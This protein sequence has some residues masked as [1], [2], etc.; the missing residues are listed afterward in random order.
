MGARESD[1]GGG[2]GGGVVIVSHLL[3][4]PALSVLSVLSHSHTLARDP[5]HAICCTVRALGCEVPLLSKHPLVYRHSSA[6]SPTSACESPTHHHFFPYT[7]NTILAH[8]ANCAATL[9]T[10]IPP[11]TVHTTRHSN[12]PQSNRQTYIHHRPLRNSPRLGLP[13][14]GASLSPPET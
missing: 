7:I 8:I 13:I 12:R 3:V 2:G 1:G 14:P 11:L 9:P 4:I 5:T 10:T 6:T